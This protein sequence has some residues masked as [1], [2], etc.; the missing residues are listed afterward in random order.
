LSKRREKGFPISAEI[1]TNVTFFDAYSIAEKLVESYAAM[2][3]DNIGNI[4]DAIEN[5][6]PSQIRRVI[7][8]VVSKIERD[9]IDLLRNIVEDC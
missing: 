6:E 9:P 4:L 7:T 1:V 5:L 8:M 2:Q 3:T